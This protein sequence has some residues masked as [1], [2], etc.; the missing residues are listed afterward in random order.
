MRNSFVSR[1]NKKTK[2]LTVGGTKA[3]QGRERNGAVTVAA[4]PNAVR[5]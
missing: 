1:Q 2:S 3:P 5:V 4:D